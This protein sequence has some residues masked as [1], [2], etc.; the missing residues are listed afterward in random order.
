M[1]LHRSGRKGFTLIELLVVIAII[2]ILIALLLPAVQQAREA[3]R[4]TQCK[5]NLKQI[6][7]ALHNYHDVHD[8]FPPAN[9]TMGNCCGTPSH[10]N[11]AIAILPFIDQ[12]PLYNQ[13]DSN[14]TNEDPANASVR[15][16]ILAAYICPSDLNTEQLE[17]PASG[18]GSGLD[19]APGSYRAVNG[20][21][22]GSNL[23]WADNRG[24][25]SNSF[26]KDNRGVLHHVSDVA[27]CEKMANI[28]DG[29][30]NTLMVGEYHT[31]SQNRRRTFWAYSYT[32]YSNSTIHIGMPYTLLNDYDK[33]VSLS[34]NGSNVCKRGFGSFHVGGIQFLLADGSVRFIST[35]I[36][37]NTL[38]A[39]GTILGGETVG[40]F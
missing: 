31:S 9:I 24:D 3:A 34:T 27:G 15:E 32:S 5:N 11:W 21:T 33:C 29:S 26:I 25:M 39:L 10:I 23:R 19:Y 36:D 18:P 2:A 22:D 8:R 35:N 38:G 1:L 13:Y 37:T 14:L 4:R 30:S 12:A 17:R 28:K 40:E 7:L 20:T 6:G 16:Q